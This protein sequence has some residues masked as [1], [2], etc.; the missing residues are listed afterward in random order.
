MHEADDDAIDIGL[1]SMNTENEEHTRKKELS[2]SLADR[3]QLKKDRSQY[4]GET[5]RLKISG[6]GAVKEVTFTPQSSRKKSN[7]VEELKTA[8]RDRD[9]TKSDRRRRGVKSLGLKTPFK[10]L[11]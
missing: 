8:K 7:A 5:K 1:G 10:H 2:L 6:Q 9:D 11:Q 4:V 3:L